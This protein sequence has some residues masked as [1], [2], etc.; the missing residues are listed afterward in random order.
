MR[1]NHYYNALSD[2]IKQDPLLHSRITSE[3]EVCKYTV[4][5]VFVDSEQRL[6]EWKNVNR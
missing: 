3:P 2:N 1:L 4:Y 5:S 6:V